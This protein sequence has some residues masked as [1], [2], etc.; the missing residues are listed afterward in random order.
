MKP[1]DVNAF[2]DDLVQD[3]MKRVQELCKDIN[4]TFAHNVESILKFTMAKSQCARLL[5]LKGKDR[6][7]FEEHFFQM[8][9]KED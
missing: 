4:P 9:F 7:E 5:G 8:C 3:R 1:P 6:T 2:K